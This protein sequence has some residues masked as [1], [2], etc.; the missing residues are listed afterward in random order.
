MWDTSPQRFRFFPTVCY[1]KKIAVKNNFVHRS[2]CTS[3]QVYLR[4][5]FL[6]VE[7][8][9]QMV[10]AFKIFTDLTK[11]PS[12]GV[13]SVNSP[14]SSVSWQRL[15]LLEPNYP[16][17]SSGC[18]A[19]GLERPACLGRLT[20]CYAQHCTRK[21]LSAASRLTDRCLQGACCRF[22]TVLGTS[23]TF[24]ALGSLRCSEIELHPRREVTAF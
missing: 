14:T 24:L 9:E 19:V 1:Y 8:W 5:K 20:L 12:I 11:S 4:N 10:Y 2:L 13:V 6:E 21:K 18:H 22:S 7:L 16:L 23:A 15:T 17:S 3:L